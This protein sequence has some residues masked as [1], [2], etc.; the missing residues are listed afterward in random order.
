[1]VKR[2]AFDKHM[3]KMIEVDEGTK[4]NTF[5]LYSDYAS[6][7]AELK[8]WQDGN[9]AIVQE[10][11]ELREKVGRLRDINNDLKDANSNL[12]EETVSLRADLSNRCEECGAKLSSYPNG[13]P[14]CGAPVCCQQC[15]KIE[16]LRA[17]LK[18][19][20]G[21]RDG[22]KLFPISDGPSVPWRVLRPHEKQCRIN[23]DQSLEAIANRGGLSSAEAWCIVNDQ[24]WRVATN[25]WSLEHLKKMWKDYANPIAMLQADLAACREDLERY[26]GAMG[27]I[28]K[29]R[30]VIL[31]NRY[32][33]PK[34]EDIAEFVRVH[35][36]PLK[37]AIREAVRMLDSG[38]VTESG[39]G[40]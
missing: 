3:N 38:K 16:H 30:Q 18:R 22:N 31:K 15:C 5:V 13:C 33:K 20:E 27:P 26:K 9:P 28:I 25:T 39:R 19:V 11:E 14:T 6:L 35:T 36:D 17:D 37:K 34:T 24:T 40:S 12:F 4:N 8:S 10:V 21:E 1:M 7:R 2:Y 32:K 23:H 29:I